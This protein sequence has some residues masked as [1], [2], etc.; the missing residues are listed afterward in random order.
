[1]RK[2]EGR[3]CLV[4]CLLLLLGVCARASAQQTSDASK[5]GETSFEPDTEKRFRWTTTGKVYLRYGAAKATQPTRL[6]GFGQYKP[7]RSLPTWLLHNLRRV[8][9][10]GI[11]ERTLLERS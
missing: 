1:M 8:S 3:L 4:L 2:V 10:S 9:Q 5:T 11:P 6:F 7:R